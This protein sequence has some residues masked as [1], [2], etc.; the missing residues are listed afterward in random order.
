VT[1]FVPGLGWRGIELVGLAKN[2]EAGRE[3]EIELRKIGQEIRMTVDGVR[4]I[5]SILARLSQDWASFSHA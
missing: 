3:Y 4:V 1:E 5:E 2:L